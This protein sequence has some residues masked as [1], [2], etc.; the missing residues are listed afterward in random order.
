MDIQKDLIYLVLKL[1]KLH[2]LI[3]M[4]LVVKYNYYQ[5]MGY[6]NNTLNY[7]KQLNN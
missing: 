3:K 4:G 2:Q 1:F 6:F 5:S 7:S